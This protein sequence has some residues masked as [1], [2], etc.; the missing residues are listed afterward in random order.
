MTKL[1]IFCSSRAN[2]DEHAWPNWLLKILKRHP[3]DS[4]T[5]ETMHD[6]QLPRQWGGVD[7]AIKLKCVCEKTCNNGWMH[8][9]EDRT[10]PILSPMIKDNPMKLTGVQQRTI[11]EWIVKTAMVFDIAKPDKYIFYDKVERSSFREHLIPPS[12]NAIW[13]ARYSGSALGDAAT[14][15]RTSFAGIRKEGPRLIKYHVHTMCFG[16]LALQ[17]FSWKPLVHEPPLLVEINAVYGQWRD[18][19]LPIWP[20][21]VL[22]IDWPPKLSLSDGE[23][24][25]EAFANRFNGMINIGMPFRGIR[26]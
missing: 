12:N 16:R 4:T 21:N 1:C 3:E 6:H 5:I 22:P 15:S 24:S 8:K 26:P 25:L 14:S 2:S 13:I 20:V 17:I 19:A 23:S 18:A 10:K 11:V 9:L 7:A